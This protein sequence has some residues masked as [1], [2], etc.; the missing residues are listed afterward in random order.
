MTNCPGLADSSSGDTTVGIGSSNYLFLHSTLSNVRLIDDI[1]IGQQNIYDN[2]NGGTA[3]IDLAVAIGDFNMTGI[4][5]HS[6]ELI[7]IGDTNLSGQS[8]GSNLFDMVVL[9]DDNANTC[10]TPNGSDIHCLLEIQIAVV[11]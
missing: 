3:N 1:A 9:G 7:A 6:A 5:G 4:I 11:I 10:V 8:S 2:S